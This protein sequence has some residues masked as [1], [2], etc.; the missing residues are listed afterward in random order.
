M[1]P[2]CI[3]LHNKAA[4]AEWLT[5]LEQYDKVIEDDKLLLY[6][7]WLLQQCLVGEAGEKMAC[8]AQE[9][10]KK[11]DSFEGVL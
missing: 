8:L 9:V 6:E 2:I 1:L 7:A 10:L 3:Y 4:C 11:M 5:E